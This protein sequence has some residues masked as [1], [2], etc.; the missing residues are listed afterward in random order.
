MHL[1]LHHRAPRLQ[2]ALPEKTTGS[3]H[4]IFIMKSGKTA[5]NTRDKKKNAQ[6]YSERRHS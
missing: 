2:I 3:C 5:L 6:N 4:H 1:K